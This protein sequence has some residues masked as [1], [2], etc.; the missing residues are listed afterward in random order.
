MDSFKSPPALVDTHAHLSMSPL[1]EQVGAVIN[2]AADS[3]VTQII[4]VGIDGPDAARA[5][6]LTR[7]FENVFACVGFHPHNAAEVGDKDLAEMEKL[8]ADPKVRGYGEVGLDFFRDWSP[9][10][11]QIAIFKEQ[12]ALAQRLGKPIVI[13]LR[14]AYTMG[15]DM[16]ESAAPFA[17]A[18]VIHCFSGVREDAERA[19][20]LG[21]F[22]SIPGPITYK[23]NELLRDIVRDAPEDRLLL[24]TD[25][26][27]LSPEPLRGK[28]NEP[29]NVRYTA[30]KVAEVRGVSFEDIA[31]ITTANARR[32]FGLPD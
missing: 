13:H 25:C 3:G 12:I 17:H 4:T 15:L 30:Q 18:G 11:R 7:R 26:P 22:I 19:F 1:Y 14:S 9:R 8:A 2:R 10:D 28:D 29:A 20:A 32:V 31:R 21:F 27:F 6:E 24:E 5:V 23:K 16:L